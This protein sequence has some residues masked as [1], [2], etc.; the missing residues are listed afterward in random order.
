MKGAKTSSSNKSKNKEKGIVIHPTGGIQIS[1]NQ[2]SNLQNFPPIS[3]AQKTNPKDKNTATIQSDISYIQKPISDRLFLSNFTS[4]KF[5]SN[6]EMKERISQ[7]ISQRLPQGFNWYPFEKYKTLQFYRNIL[8]DTNSVYFKDNISSSTN[9]SKCLIFQVISVPD[10]KHPLTTSIQFSFNY[11][12]NTL[13]KHYDYY[14]YINA[15]FNVFLVQS[16]DHSWFISFHPDCLQKNKTFPIWFF[17]WW[18]RYG[19]LSDIFPEEVS[20]AFQLFDSKH[21]CKEGYEFSSIVFFLPNF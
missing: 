17:D 5:S 20:K 10:W 4:S 19:A 15:W 13:P 12:D 18:E 6:D 14:D 1:N 7:H 8:R 11:Q 2:F 3:Y 16:Y 9:F 21:K